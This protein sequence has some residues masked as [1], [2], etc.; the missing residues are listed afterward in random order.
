MF[1][2]MFFCNQK[3]H[4]ACPSL[5]I[6]GAVKYP[7]S[8]GMVEDRTNEATVANLVAAATSKPLIQSVER[9]SSLLNIPGCDTESSFQPDCPH[10]VLLGTAR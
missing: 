4:C 3:S 5:L 6:T 10:C 2:A 7:A 8:V 1:E 9:P